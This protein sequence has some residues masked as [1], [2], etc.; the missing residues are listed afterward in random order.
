MD[1]IATA[2]GTPSPLVPHP[3][4]AISPDVAA[5]ASPAPCATSTVTP[6]LHDLSSPP[7]DVSASA[8]AASALPALRDT[9]PAAVSLFPSSPAAAAPSPLSGCSPCGS[10]IAFPLPVRPDISGGLLTDSAGY[11]DPRAHSGPDLGLDGGPRS[12]GPFRGVAA[13][14]HGPSHSPATQATALSPPSEVQSATD[15]GVQILVIGTAP[16]PYGTSWSDSSLVIEASLHDIYGRDSNFEFTFCK[17]FCN[18]PYEGVFPERLNIAPLSTFDMVLFVGCNRL[19]D[20]FS[21]ADWTATDVEPGLRCLLSV[22]KPLPTSRLGFVE[23][24]L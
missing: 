9:S 13:L 10:P 1:E 6:S 7:P 12:S 18:G 19:P 24:E 23:G 16:S 4:L 8:T 21:N 22:L 5:P 3:A 11:V 20:M 2:A 14:E 17:R 15:A